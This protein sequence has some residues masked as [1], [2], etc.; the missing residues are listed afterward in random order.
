MRHLAQAILTVGVLLLV[1]TAALY[2]Q[3]PDRRRSLTPLTSN[4][5]IS[6]NTADEPTL[7]LLP[8]IGRRTA[9]A[10][11]RMREER[12]PFTSLKQL[13]DVPNIGDARLREIEPW[14]DFE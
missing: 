1:V 11:I 14:I 4:Q 8:G 13:D 5:R 2:W 7:R 12:G 9:M 10:I 6:I 3:R